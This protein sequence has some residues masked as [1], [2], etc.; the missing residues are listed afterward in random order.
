MSVS[1]LTL[2]L[3][4]ETRD[5]H[6][7]KRGDF[8]ASLCLC[9]V[10][11]YVLFVDKSSHKYLDHCRTQLT[12][13]SNV[14]SYFIFS[15]KDKKVSDSPEIHSRWVF[16]EYFQCLPESDDEHESWFSDM[17]QRNGLNDATYFGSYEGHQIGYGDINHHV[18]VLVNLGKQ[19]HWTYKQAQSRLAVGGNVCR[20]SNISP[21]RRE[22]QPQQFIARHVRYCEERSRVC[23]GQR[24]SICP[25]GKD[26]PDVVDAGAE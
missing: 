22:E 26:R 19:A 24:L 18:L 3:R 10:G 23:S 17:L 11:D 9:H 6:H 25:V 12:L 14:G 7:A 4:F 1:T 2:K 5:S 21:L 16:L 15:I 13:D 8:W 20:P